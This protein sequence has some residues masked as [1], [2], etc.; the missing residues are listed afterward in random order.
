MSSIIDALKKSDSNRSNESGANLNQIKFGQQPPQKSRRGI[1]LL[2]ALFLLVAFGVFAWSQG[3]HH[4]AIA[5]AKSWFGSEQVDTE[6]TAAQPETQVTSQQSQQPV[7]QVVTK[8][9]TEQTNKL[10]PPKANEVKAKRQ[11]IE[12]AQTDADSDKKQQLEVI[13]ANK[14]DAK[15]QDAQATSAD[16]ELTVQ[17]KPNKSSQTASVDETTD[18][19][20]QAAIQN[21]KDLEP[22]LKQD[23]LLVHQI[24]FEIRK[25]IPP[26]K[27]NIHIFDPD[28]ENRM[29]ILNGIKYA[30]GDIIEELV[31][32]GEINQE[33]VVLEFEGIKFLIPK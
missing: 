26:I 19:A 3:W 5:Q 1:L 12:Q 21:R 28:P 10:T 15:T 32:V 20:K 25:N 4:S 33:G 23:Y 9:S 8:S 31:T 24:D 6:Q 2:V 13:T 7:S 17:P 30:T 11:A 27:L 22:R 14:T 16:E 29:V 18:N